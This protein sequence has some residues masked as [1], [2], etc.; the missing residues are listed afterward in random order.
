M[1]DPSHIVRRHDA[2][3]RIGYTFDGMTLLDF[4]GAA[5]A[6]ACILNSAHDL[7]AKL[8]NHLSLLEDEFDLG[9]SRYVAQTNAKNLPNFYDELREPAISQTLGFIV[10]LPDIVLTPLGASGSYYVLSPTISIGFD[11]EEFMG[12]ITDGKP[13][14]IWSPDIF[15]SPRNPKSN[16]KY[17][18]KV[19]TE[20]PYNND[21]GLGFSPLRQLTSIIARNEILQ[22][23]ML[24][25]ARVVDPNFQTP[26]SGIEKV[27]INSATC[28]SNE[29]FSRIYSQILDA[30]DLSPVSQDQR[31]EVQF[32]DIAKEVFYVSGA[33]F[34][35]DFNPPLDSK[36]NFFWCTTE[37]GASGLFAESIM[38]DSLVISGLAFNRERGITSLLNQHDQITRQSVTSLVTRAIMNQIVRW[39]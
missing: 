5:D 3:A 33:L 32:R 4:A 11:A 30:G 7:S 17:W 28:G 16:W 15:D 8:A 34:D 39:L 9:D 26:F 2:C 10:D 12:N 27:Y 23:H 14:F 19:R 29:I 21:G 25:I 35:S 31:Y 37:E 6:E 24:D 22:Q 36:P 13:G 1:I 38:G 20:L 18:L